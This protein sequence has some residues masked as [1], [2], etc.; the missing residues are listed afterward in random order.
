MKQEISKQEIR[1]GINK[2][3]S[4]APS[5]DEIKKIKKIAMSKN[6]KLG[7]FRKT[8]CKRC[9]SYFNSKNS[10]TRIKNGFKIIRCK[11]CSQINRWEMK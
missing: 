6:I 5:P 2:V 9:F 3:F 10:E 1:E 11:K 7:L 8:F 4:G